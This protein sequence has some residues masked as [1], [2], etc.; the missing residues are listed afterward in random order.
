MLIQC[1]DSEPLLIRNGNSPW[2]YNTNPLV[3]C[4]ACIE[5]ATAGEAIDR[6]AQ[7]SKL[8]LRAGADPTMYMDFSHADP[9]ETEKYFLHQLP[10][11]I[12][13]LDSM[14]G[15]CIHTH[16]ETPLTTLKDLLQTIISEGGAFIQWRH[17]ELGHS[18]SH[19][20]LFKST[21]SYL[22]KFSA[23][24]YMGF[25][26][27]PTFKNHRGRNV[28]E[29]VFD[30][31]PI[32]DEGIDLQIAGI[33]LPYMIDSSARASNSYTIFARDYD[34]YNIFERVVAKR[35][36]RSSILNDSLDTEEDASVC[37]S[38]LEDDDDS[39]GSYRQ[40]L[41]YC[42]LLRSGLYASYDLPPLPVGPTFTSGYT[43]QHYRALLYLKSWD[44]KADPSILEHPL[45]IQD[46]LCEEERICA[47]A[48][49]DWKIFDLS[50]MESRLDSAT[51]VEE[52]Y[53]SDSEDEGLDRVVTEYSRDSDSEW[54]ENPATDDP[55]DPRNEWSEESVQGGT[56]F[57]LESRGPEYGES[58]EEEAEEKTRE[59]EEEKVEREVEE[60]AEEDG[61]EE[62]E[63]EAQGEVEEE[64]E[65]EVKVMLGASEANEVFG[66]HERFL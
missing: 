42:V 40:D 47:P 4:L 29:S 22:E 24:I 17:Q 14:V 26:T 13:C 56:E 20:H 18:V 38:G 23:M 1:N 30:F 36:K 31:A 60:E 59:E 28:F 63:V 43:P 15:I 51:F 9:R 48:F 37:S 62:T 64:T 50:M 57:G 3:I 5:K 54:P 6:F 44:M 27:H 34:G 46:P 55:E 52:L 12:L 7:C 10:P 39:Y 53:D 61:Q 35:S 8:L 45:L 19:Q 16:Y 49:C 65:E 25:G 66:W 58:L 21:L 11:P 33:L 2:N 41:L 32:L